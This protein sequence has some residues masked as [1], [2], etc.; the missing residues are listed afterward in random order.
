MSKIRR[1]KKMEKP[2][3]EEDVAISSIDGEGGGG[4]VPAVVVNS[5]A[6]LVK[7]VA[8]EADSVCE[9]ELRPWIGGSLIKKLKKREAHD[10]DED[11]DEDE[12]ILLLPS[13][14]KGRRKHRL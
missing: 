10:E 11:E 1:E 6:A 3:D 8:D 7:E 2:D 13:I 14:A 9:E 12:G 4:E 5:D